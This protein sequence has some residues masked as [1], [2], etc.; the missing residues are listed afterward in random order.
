MIPQ[1]TTD[2]PHAKST[3]TPN[4]HN[5]K[6]T[7]VQVVRHTLRQHLTTRQT[8]PPTTH[9]IPKLALDYRNHRLH[10]PTLTIQAT[11]LRAFHQL[12]TQHARPRPQPTP[13]AVSAAPHPSTLHPA[14]QTLRPPTAKIVP[15][16]PCV[17][18]TDALGHATGL[19]T[20]RPNQYRAPP[21]FPQSTGSRYP[22][23]T[24]PCA[25]HAAYSRDGSDSTHLPCRCESLWCPQ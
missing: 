25:T 13:H 6:K 2:T 3:H 18:H 23:Q 7:A 4:A 20:S 1:L 11:R 16:A 12:R 5:N 10:L 21:A 14:H 9:T 15:N 24:C 17:P 22:P 19:T 8:Q